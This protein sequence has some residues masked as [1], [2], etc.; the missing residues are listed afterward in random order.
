M[1]RAIRLGAGE[2]ET[3][4]PTLGLESLQMSLGQLLFWAKS[5]SRGCCQG[6]LE[7]KNVTGGFPCLPMP[8]GGEEGFLAH[9]L[10]TNILLLQSD[11]VP[12]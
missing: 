8:Q 10:N 2:T 7:D 9:N 3:Q 11:L 4:S 6:K 12:G 1:G 5:T